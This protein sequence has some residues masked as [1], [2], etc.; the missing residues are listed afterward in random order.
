[1]R[2]LFNNNDSYAN[3]LYLSGFTVWRNYDF[4]LYYQ[5]AGSVEFTNN[6]A[7]EN[8]VSMWHL[9]IGPPSLSHQ[10]H[11]KYALVKDSKSDL[12][13]RLIQGFFRIVLGHLV[14][15]LNGPPESGACWNG[16]S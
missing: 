6:V 8:G 1:M 10:R 7:I 13:H 11:N 2:I 14:I 4:G 12:G 3:V 15:L 5:G 9:V 16:R